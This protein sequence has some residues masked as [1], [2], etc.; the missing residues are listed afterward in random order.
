MSI[1]RFSLHNVDVVLACLLIYSVCVCVCLC[2]CLGSSD[3]EDW[4]ELNDRDLKPVPPGAKPVLGPAAG[5]TP[6]PVAGP[7][8]GPAVVPDAVVPD[9]VVPDAVVPDAV[10]L[11]AVVPDA[12]GPDA[13]AELK[14]PNM[15]ILAK[16]P[17]KVR[18]VFVFF[19]ST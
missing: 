14:G 10:V 15:P 4:L 12:L 17:I 1:F 5:K 6:A 9:A 18:V 7:H 19:I 2:V 11:D 8:L 16:P 13:V 3:R